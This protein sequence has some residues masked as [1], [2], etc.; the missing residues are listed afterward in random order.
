MK[1]DLMGVKIT[2]HLKVPDEV[3][4]S[5]TISLKKLRADENLQTFCKTVYGLNKKLSK[6]SK[7]SSFD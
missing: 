6:N 7:D 5:R 2:I 4:V 1:F 3:K